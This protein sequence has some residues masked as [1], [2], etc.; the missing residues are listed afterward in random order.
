MRLQ[1]SDQD[2]DGSPQ[3]QWAPPANDGRDCS[4][5]D[6]ER[7]RPEAGWYGKESARQQVS[8]LFL[9]FLILQVDNKWI[10][11]LISFKIL[12]ENVFSF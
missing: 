10:I 9:S 1:L 4:T 2:G 3:S 7:F 8:N 5:A 6:V 12:F 11:T